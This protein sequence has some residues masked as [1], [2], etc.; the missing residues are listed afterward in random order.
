M[1]PS[2]ANRKIGQHPRCNT[3][4][5]LVCDQSTWF[6]RKFSAVPG[7]ITEGLGFRV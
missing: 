1:M 2:E 7:G 4:L 5:G 6:D 3:S